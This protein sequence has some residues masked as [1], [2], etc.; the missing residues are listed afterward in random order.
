MEVWRVS[1]DE[2]KALIDA[3][4]GEGRGEQVFALIYD[5]QT[6]FDLVCADT[7]TLSATDQKDIAQFTETGRSW[8][9][10][11][12]ILSDLAQRKLIGWGNHL[13][14]F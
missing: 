2:L 3:T 8:I 12:L 13:I 5:E 14:E 1:A 7:Y 9:D 4:Y 11:S 6:G 10:L